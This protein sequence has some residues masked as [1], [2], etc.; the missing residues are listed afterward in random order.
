MKNLDTKKIIFIIIAFLVLVLMPLALNQSFMNHVMTMMCI[1][2][3]VGMGWNLIGG[4]AGQ[5]SNGHALFYGFGAY[6]VALGMSLFKLSPW[7]SMWIGVIIS[8]LIAYLIGKPLLRFHGHIF[9]IATM[10]IAESGRI[11]FLNTRF[12]GGATGVYFYQP[13]QSGFLSM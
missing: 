10:A 11:I 1:W 4:Y 6:S 3:I 12:L 9:A 13:G 8:V 2:S 5:V 7:I